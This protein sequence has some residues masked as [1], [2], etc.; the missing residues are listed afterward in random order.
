M[1]DCFQDWEA[2]CKKRNE[3]FPSML[4]TDDANSLVVSG[5]RRWIIQGSH[6]CRLEREQANQRVDSTAMRLLG[7]RNETMPTVPSNFDANSVMV[8]ELKKKAAQLMRS[9]VLQIGGLMGLCKYW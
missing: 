3:T 5:L 2:C 1:T 9:R 6:T 4:S 8:T 7:V